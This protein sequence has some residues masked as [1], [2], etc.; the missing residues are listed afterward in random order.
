MASPIVY[1]KIFGC[2]TCWEKGGGDTASQDT[3]FFSCQPPIQTLDSI[4][5][6]KAFWFWNNRIRLC[7]AEVRDNFW[8]EGEQC[9]EGE[10]QFSEGRRAM[11]RGR[12]TIFRRK[13][14]NVQRERNNFQKEGEQCS[15]REEQI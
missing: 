6:I 5:A 8:K 1:I 3:L 2:L 4:Q 7:G 13:E 15:E 11:F 9:S 10:E 12:G 14:R